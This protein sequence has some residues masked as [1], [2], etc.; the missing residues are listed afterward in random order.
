MN[1]HDLA[2]AAGF[3]DGEGCFTLYARRKRPNPIYRG[4]I[5]AT[6]VNITPLKKLVNLFG[7][8][9][10][11]HHRRDGPRSHCYSWS[12]SGYNAVLDAI[13]PYLVGK[14]DQATI[15]RNFLRSQAARRMR[16]RTNWE[17]STDQWYRDRL[18]AAKAAPA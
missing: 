2:W 6:Q 12:A 4:H 7:G 17:L 11:T 10:H 9:I 1:S 18:R 5:S 16:R 3:L 8:T 14:R 15:L 13:I